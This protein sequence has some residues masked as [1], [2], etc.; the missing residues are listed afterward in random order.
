[1][2]RNFVRVVGLVGAFLYAVGVQALGLGDVKL[3]SGLNE[4]LDA[5]IKL[6]NTGDLNASQIIIKLASAEDFA[7]AG[8]ER[9]FF[10]TNFKYKTKLDGKGGGVVKITTKEL[11]REP[12]LNFLLE[13]KWPSG[14]L[15]R[16]YTLLVDLPVFKSTNNAPR[17]SQA[18]AQKSAAP[19]ASSSSRQTAN[20]EP[21]RK[22]QPTFTSRE[23]ARAQDTGNSGTLTTRRHDTLWKLALQVR[24]SASIPAQKVM[25]AMQTLNPDGCIDNNI[26]LLKTGAVLRI[27]TLEDIERIDNDRARMAV[28]EQNER[29]RSASS[30]QR[31]LDAT[32]TRSTPEIVEESDSG[33]LRLTTSSSDDATSTGGTDSEAGGDGL[34]AKLLAAEEAAEKAN[35]ENIELR[36]KVEDLEAELL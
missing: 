1:M 24:P 12:Y 21:V 33:S 10:L 18:P 2:F 8:A 28:A 11:V 35:A 31:Q 27:P 20:R 26:N 25:V 30:G 29:W 5:E 14:K 4:P 34:G 16:E 19:A 36:S 17:V 23:S 6:L 22:T 32:P 15:V 9:D 13:A 3:N 7:R